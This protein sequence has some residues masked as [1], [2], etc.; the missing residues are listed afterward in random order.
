MTHTTAL[1]D[2]YSGAAAPEAVITAGA[3]L[4]L[5]GRVSVVLLGIRGLVLVAHP[6][7]EP[8]AFENAIRLA[9]KCARRDL[10]GE[11][12]AALQGAREREG[13]R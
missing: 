12:D 8:A 11:L 1:L 13:R 2:T 6:E 4:S 5:D 3:R 7:S 10:I 9:A